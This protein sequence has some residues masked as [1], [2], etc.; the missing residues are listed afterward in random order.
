MTSSALSPRNTHTHTPALVKQVFGCGPTKPMR[1][2]WLLK[3][4]VDNEQR[5]AQSKA[6]R[7]NEENVF[8]VD[9]CRM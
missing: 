9:G 6:G 1:H 3:Y 7:K 8:Y 5:L 4:L 2:R